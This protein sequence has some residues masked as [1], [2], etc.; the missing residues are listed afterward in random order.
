MPTVSSDG[1]SIINAAASGEG[2]GPWRKSCFRNARA[3]PFWNGAE[4]AQACTDLK[5]VS[6]LEASSLI[7]NYRQDRWTLIRYLQRRWRPHNP[8]V[9]A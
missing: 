2:G 7:R 1:E 8:T 4:I 5:P 6:A 9:L 3:L